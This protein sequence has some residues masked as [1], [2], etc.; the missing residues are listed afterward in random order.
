MEKDNVV[1]GI[2]VTND[3]HGEDGAPLRC[4]H[5]GYAVLGAV[6]IVCL[7]GTIVGLAVYFGTTDDNSPP[8]TAN[9]SPD[10]GTGI[11]GDSLSNE[12]G[13]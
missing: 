7:V 4:K 2:P 11:V 1:V 3:Q 10:Y 5:V 8:P 6:G 9:P 12:S 13:E